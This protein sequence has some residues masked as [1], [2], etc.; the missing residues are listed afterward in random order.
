MFLNLWDQ[1]LNFL[2]PYRVAVQFS[3]MPRTWREDYEN[4]EKNIFAPLKPDVYVWTWIDENNPQESRDFCFKYNVGGR[5]KVY[6][7]PLRLSGFPIINQM[8]SMKMVA[9]DINPDNAIPMLYARWGCN[10]LRKSTRKEYDVVILARTEIQ[11]ERPPNRNEL[12]AATRSV[13]IPR[14]F[15]AGDGYNDLF[16][17]TSPHGADV[18]TS[19]YN[20]LNKLVFDD[21]VPMNPHNLLKRAITESKVPVERIDYPLYL[22]KEATWNK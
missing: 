5:G 1:V 3:G 7:E 16:A 19:L 20:R 14:G 22:R 9:H 2:K 8:R 11:M 4:F 13:L 17:I 18:Y 12:D 21:Y 15:N 6:R 10:E